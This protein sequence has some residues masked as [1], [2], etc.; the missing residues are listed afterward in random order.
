MSA[1]PS[2]HFRRALSSLAILSLALLSCVDAPSAPTE[3][4]SPGAFL[5]AP[6]LSLV[7]SNGPAQS[8]AQA[9]ALDEAFDLV[10]AFRMVVRRASNNEIVVDTVISVTAGQGEYD[11]AVPVVTT[12]KGHPR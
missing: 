12:T 3:E 11:L 1:S 4:P 9:E 5:F 7:A 8:V 2:R 10:D 6:R